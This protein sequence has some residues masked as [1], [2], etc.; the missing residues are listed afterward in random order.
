M[1]KLT[2]LKSRKGCYLPIIWGWGIPVNSQFPHVLIN[3]S[4]VVSSGGGR[5]STSL[6]SP[7]PSYLGQAGPCIL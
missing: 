3:F 1:E 2:A 4:G 5:G 7:L 6:S